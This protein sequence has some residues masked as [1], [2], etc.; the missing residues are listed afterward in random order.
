M[1]YLQTIPFLNFGG[2]VAAK[3][4]LGG[5]KNKIFKQYL[6]YGKGVTGEVADRFIAQNADRAARTITDNLIDKAFG[7]G[8]EAML[9][10]VKTAHVLDFL[11]RAAKARIATG[12]LEGIE[13]GQQHLL[14]QRY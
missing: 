5:V 1:D 8:A 12:V 7:E 9:K 4:I 6:K 10:K 13:E 14:Q 11:K 2:K 3:S